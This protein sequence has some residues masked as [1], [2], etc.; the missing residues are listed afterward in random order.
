M[1]PIL[2]Y[3]LR[4][5]VWNILCLFQRGGR[6]EVGATRQHLIKFSSGQ[7]T[8]KSDLATISNW[9]FYKMTLSEE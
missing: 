4:G 8:Y 2:N 3:K 5:S 6:P 9:G 1:S 7:N